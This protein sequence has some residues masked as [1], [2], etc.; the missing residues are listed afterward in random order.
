MGIRSLR[1]RRLKIRGPKIWK[2]KAKDLENGDSK[3]EDLGNEYSLSNFG[4]LKGNLKG[5]GLVFQ[6]FNILSC[7]LDPVIL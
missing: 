6:V 7:L 5:R 2:P 1:S 3:A 4:E